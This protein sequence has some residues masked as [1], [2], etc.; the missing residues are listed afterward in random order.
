VKLSNKIPS[1]IVLAVALLLARPSLAAQQTIGYTLPN[2]L[3]VRARH[4]ENT[5]VVCARLVFFIHEGSG[6]VSSG[7]DTTVPEGTAYLMQKVLPLLGCGGMGRADFETAKDRSGI[8]SRV[9][10]GQG[11]I[12]WTFE[13]LPANAEIMIQTLADESLRPAWHKSEGLPSALAALWDDR[14]S[15]ER[16][17]AVRA[18]RVAAG[19]AAAGR[20]PEAQIDQ[21][22]VVALWSAAMRRPERAI[23]SMVGDIES[24][25]LR[26]TINQHF[27]PWDGP[28]RQGVET[29][30]ISP[31]TAPL[32]GMAQPRTSHDD[33]PAKRVV[34]LE[35]AFPEVWVAWDLGA[36]PPQE[37]SAL[38]ALIPWLLRET[39][40][41]T[42][43]TI[44]DVEID[45]GGRWLRATGHDGVPPDSLESRLKTLLA[46]PV[47]QG[48]LDAAL[49]AK[50]EY[51]RTCWLRPQRALEQLERGETQTVAPPSLVDMLGKCLAPENLTVLVMQ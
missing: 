26:R 36:I 16:E 48:Q 35:S 8:L 14:A 7:T 22:G 20:L 43:G 11:W 40:P 29:L 47:T 4:L 12:S 27:G 28:M 37:A 19:D 15:D 23:L 32:P 45:P 24:I 18:F 9:A 30:G 13:S 1:A 49:K 46:A 50:D 17:K 31:K 25:P 21:D 10:A 39:L 33:K 2:G 6:R 34:S 51:E 44:R 42:D 3:E 5:G 38:A 41:A